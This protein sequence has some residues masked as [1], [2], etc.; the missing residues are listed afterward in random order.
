MNV[1]TI[2]LI[3]QFKNMG[4]GMRKDGYKSDVTCMYVCNIV[5]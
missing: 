5:C 2:I 4:I 1:V 3:G